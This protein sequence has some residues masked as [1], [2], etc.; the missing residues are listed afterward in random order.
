MKYPIRADYL[1]KGTKRR[2]G[3][4]AKKIRFIVWHDTGNPGSTAKGNVNYFKNS[5][6]SMS[7]SAHLFVDDKEII[8]CIPAVTGT[9][10]K[11]WHVIYD[12]TTDNKMYGDDAND[13][14]IGVEMCWGGNVNNTESYKRT[15]WLLA[16]LCHKFGL[17]PKRD[18]VGHDTLDPKRKVD[19][20]N[21]LRKMGKTFAQGINDVVKEY[22]E[23]TGKTS[24]PVQQP[25]AKT[26]KTHKVVKGDTL[27]GIS[28]KYGTTVAKLKSLNPE[29][30]PLALQIGTVL[31]I[32]P[33][34]KAEPKPATTTKVDP[35]L[36]QYLK[37]PPVR[38]YPGKPVKRGARGRDVEAI[39]R[40]VKVSVDGSF[41][42]QT[43]QA[44]K[45]YQKR[46]P[47]LVAD[48]VVDYNTWNVMF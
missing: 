3:A 21:A 11:A 25:S 45:N 32:D 20:T 1:P 36:A 17:D 26:G 5:A 30:D 9:P 15:V 38:P 40:A 31:V 29:V 2:G 42:A 41:G 10:E 6:N 34:V 27:W 39:Q 48:G 16:Y 4:K 33:T 8:E 13:A 35:R 37:T 47:F 14:A 18:I 24:T 23:C 46:F 44:V 43:E 19:P 12:V 7:A 22:Q 28:Q